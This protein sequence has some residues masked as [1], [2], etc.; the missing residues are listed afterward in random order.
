MSH[1]R[2]PA[3]QEGPS[4]GHLLASSAILWH[5]VEMSTGFKVPF[6]CRS[7]RLIQP[8][9]R[10][11]PPAPRV[12]R[13]PTSSVLSGRSDFSLPV[14]LHF[15]AFVP[16]YHRIAAVRSRGTPL[17]LRPGPFLRRR[18]H[19]LSPWRKRDLPG[20]WRTPDDMPRSSTPVDHPQL[21]L[22]AA[23]DAAFRSENDVGSTIRFISWLYH[24]A[25]RL[26]VYASQ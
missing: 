16:Q 9:A 24:A 26:P 5:F 3:G 7:K 6:I 15:V 19:R 11:P 13:S 8:T 4:D 20:S 25:Y 22:H 17:P 18:P 14:P 10:F 23:S 1:R 2:A 12:R 21:A